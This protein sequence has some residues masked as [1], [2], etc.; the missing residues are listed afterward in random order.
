MKFIILAIL[1]ASP[2]IINAQNTIVSQNTIGGDAVEFST[3]AAKLNNSTFVIGGYSYS[4]MNGDKATASN[5]LSDAWVVGLDANLLIDWQ[6]SIGGDSTEFISFTEP[7]L[8]GGVICGGWSSSSVS[9]TKTSAK[10]GKSDYWIFKLDQ[11]GNELWQHSFGGTDYD[12]LKDAIELSN[13]DFILAGNSSS[14][15]S[16]TKSEN[17]K[18]YSDYWILRISP[19]G[20]I[21]W[22]K[23]FGGDESELLAGLAI[24]D[25]EN[26]YVSGSSWS[27]I[28]F[29]KTEA[30]YGWDDIWI[31]KLDSNGNVLWDKTIGGDQSETLGDLLIDGNSLYVLANSKSGISGLKSEINF[32]QTDYWLTKMD[33]NG[34]I[35]WD[36]TYGGD[37]FDNASTLSLTLDKQIIISGESGSDL[38]GTKIE[39]NMGVYD[40]WPVSVDTNGVEIWQETIGGS[41][42]DQLSDVIEISDNHYL[43]VG[44]SK[45]DSDGDKQENSMGEEDYWVVELNTT[46]SL[47]S[48]HDLN[49]SIAP[50]PFNNFIK[51]GNVDDYNLAQVRLTN[52]LGETV[53]EYVIVGE[54]LE[55]DLS[56]LE[57]GVYLLHFIDNDVLIGT[58]KIVKY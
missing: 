43:L 18:G 34:N 40:M 55:L 2:F 44:D 50:N 21:I 14:N 42:W 56:H 24:D 6:T 41:D 30:S 53:G 32:G 57:S 54:E 5:G 31:V 4:G 58:K 36:K 16:A 19:L 20:A 9:G 48:V 17:S 49:L 39:G 52:F 47:N 26:I 28:S 3:S 51:L 23:T 35:V 37:W 10:Y 1:F 25:D 27:G 33:L 11:F 29:D 13:G 12:Q 7:T 15:S 46:A 38:S 45:S 22:D 8:D